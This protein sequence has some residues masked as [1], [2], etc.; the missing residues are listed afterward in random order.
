MT[1]Q[2]FHDWPN[3]PHDNNDACFGFILTNSVPLMLIQGCKLVRSKKGD[4]L[5]SPPPFIYIH[6]G[7]NRRVPHDTI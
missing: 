5:N 2:L 7:G 3:S 1:T 4:K 6:R